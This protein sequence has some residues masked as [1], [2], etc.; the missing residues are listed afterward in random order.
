MII[1][2]ADR[3]GQT[4]EYYFATKLREIRQRNADGADIINLGIGNPDLMP[5][6]DVIKT[7]IQQVAKPGVH[8]YQ[9]YKG[10]AAL[11][12]GFA[13]WYLATYGVK[14]APETEILPLMGSKEGIMHISMAF[15]N[16]GD[17]VLVPNP[18][19]LTYRSVATLLEAETVF[20]NLTPENHWYPDLDALAQQDLSRV[21]IMWVNYPHMPTGATPSRTLFKKLVAFAKQHR[22][23]LCHDNPYSLV[24]NADPMSLLSIPGAEDV[25]LELNSL[26]KSHHMA[27]WRM[28]M[29]AG[30]SSYIQAVLKVKSN[31][32]SGMLLPLQQAAVQALATE[33]QWHE[34]QNEVYRARRELVYQLLDLLECQYEKGQAG[35]FVW[36]KIPERADN[37]QDLADRILDQ[38]NVFIAPGF[39]FGSQGD[40][41]VRVSLCAPQSQIEVALHRIQQMN[42]PELQ[43]Q[44]K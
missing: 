34:E 15:L 33:Y 9:P 32:D 17:Q 26:S 44:P 37:G 21:K 41:Y 14:L 40:R 24:L 2:P 7:F 22:I 11:R 5:P 23:L 8:G 43:V 31:M 29:V 12:Q 13:R 35:M 3:L 19:Y 1:S 30:K 4:K 27:G 25:V 28:G 16:P 39:I 42:T 38:A 36:A 18:G 6:E 10:I 20:Y